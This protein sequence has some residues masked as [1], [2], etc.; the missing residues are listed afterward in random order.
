MDMLI[1]ALNTRAIVAEVILRTDEPAY[2]VRQNKKIVY[3]IGTFK[4]YVCSQG[5]RY[6][7][8]HGHLKDVIQAAYYEKDWIFSDFVTYFYELRNHYKQQ[9][10]RE[11]EQ[12]CKYILNSLYGKF[13]QKTTLE[14]IREDITYDGYFREEILDGDTGRREIVTKLFNTQLNQYGE[15]TAKHAMVAIAAHV[16]E[17]GRF[18]LWKLINEVGRER[19]LYCDTDSLT[20]RKSHIKYLKNSLS[21][22]ELGALKLEHTYNTLILNASKDY[23][24]DISIKRKGVPK[25]AKAINDNTFEYTQWCK[26]DTHLRRRIDDMYITK[27]ITKTLKRKYEKGIVNKDGTV[28]PFVFNLVS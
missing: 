20:I 4:T 7:I 27:T 12:F 26:Q 19:V 11:Y 16:T 3:P 13:G 22:S 9:K 23:E 10:N 14:E 8:D 17:Y 1:P 24:T 5:L 2:P 6:A 18:H 15:K 21:Q 25:S 28:D